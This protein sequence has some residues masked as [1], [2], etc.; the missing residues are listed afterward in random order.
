MQLLDAAVPQLASGLNSLYGGRAVVTVVLMGSHA[1][2]IDAADPRDA[3]ATVNRLLPSPDVL[4]Y[5][6][7]MYIESG[8]TA[9][10]DI[11]NVL[12]V[13]LD[14]VHFQAYCPR[15]QIHPQAMFQLMATATTNT[16]TNT[17]VVNVFRYQIVL[18]LS[19]VLALAAIGAAYALAFMTFKRDPLLY[20]SFNPQWEDRKRK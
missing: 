9:I 14:A 15:Q 3:L 6:P 11:C 5:Y 1:S 4:N 7:S 12:A 10:Q 16:T 20:G 19:I 18:W 8:S 2:F 17:T 13:E